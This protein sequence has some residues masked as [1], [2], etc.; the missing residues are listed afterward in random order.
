[1][2][3]HL[4]E[5][6]LL[7]LALRVDVHDVALEPARAR[8]T[9]H[10]STCPTCAARLAAL[11]EELTADL[12][13]DGDAGAIASAQLKDRLLRGSYD[14]GDA[15]L[16]GF[17]RRIGLLFDLDEAAVQK[18]LHDAQGETVWEVPGPIA[19][20][21]FQP[22]P[23]LSQVA[24]AGVV[25]LAPGMTFPRHRHR[26]DEHGLILR[27]SLRE[28][29]SGTMGYPGDILFMPDGS[30][31]SVTAMSTEPCLFVV[32]LYGGTPDIEWC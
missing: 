32:L 30:V 11:R 2:D 8:D 14:P 31:H 23:R 6:Q 21:H 24:E 16:H 26:G 13:S 22:G 9:Q 15:A 5:E 10:V 29:N 7:D 28:D 20:F 18:V 4:A 12:L 17:V 3:E 27:G 19:Y 1:M 25:R